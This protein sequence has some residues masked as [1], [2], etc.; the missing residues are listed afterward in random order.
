[1]GVM[2]FLVHP[3]NLMNEWPEAHRGYVH[4]SDG[5]VFPT[6][7]EIS[8]NLITCRRQFS[9]SGKF[10]VPWPVA[11]FGRPVL[12]TASLREREEPYLLPVELAR[13]TICF[14][15]NQLAY[16][17]SGGLT[18]TAEFDDAY[19]Q[20]H[21]LF[22]QAASL[23]D[24]PEEACRL[25]NEA[26]A[27]AC[28]ASKLLTN[29]FVEK[30]LALA[31][32]PDSPP[33][34][35]LGCN[36]G[37]AEPTPQWDKAFLDTFNAAE[38]A[39]GWTNVESE[40]GTYH[41]DVFDQQVEWCQ[42][43]RVLMRGGPLLD[44]STGGLPEWLR[45]W[46]HDVLNLQ[47]FVC[48][49]VE[50][51]IS[52]YVGRI[53]TWEVVARGN[54]GGALGLSEENRLALVAKAM[55]VAARVDQNS[56][57]M[58]RVD[59]P[60]GEYQARGQHRLSPF[61]FVDALTRCGIALSAVNLEIAIGF[62][63]TGSPSRAL[64]EFSWLIDRW[65][66]LKLPLHITLAFPSQAGPDPHAHADLEVDNPCWRDE[67]SDAAQAEWLDEILPLMMAKKSVA[68][69]YWAHLTDAVTH[70]F[71]HS[72]LLRPDGSPKPVLEHFQIG[73]KG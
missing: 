9:E 21:T 46:S 45:Q 32:Y 57:L 43:N 49:Y 56:L 36:L 66:M 37:L 68:A 27:K 5:R 26:I 54:T 34:F 12:G 7:I 63:P 35:S 64:L 72:G 62:R 1:M 73:L 71:P 55:E 16:W 2:R 20:A 30:K 8:D 59:Q 67:W 22:G 29:V 47:S 25:A 60:W 53:R 70:R 13:G 17:Q 6:R 50:T 38:I 40:E 18:S 11:G 41:W 14:V 3:A 58:I 52:R 31:G 28:L 19:K 23:Q 4:G 61:Q 39:L 69:V 44:L 33:P 65:S 15:R 51:A 48:D 10:H 24:Q 42:Q